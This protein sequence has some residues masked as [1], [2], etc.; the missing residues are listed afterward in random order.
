M[1]NQNLV[2]N[3]G[4]AC[5]IGAAIFS[6]NGIWEI[7]QP[8]ISMDPP[9][10]LDP[11]H[12]RIGTLIFGF[13]CVPAFFA[14]QLGYYLAGATGKNWFAKLIILVFAVGA[15]VYAC[16]AIIQTVTLDGSPLFGIGIMTTQWLCPVLLGIAALFARTVALWKRLFPFLLVIVP[17]I[18]FPIFISNDLPLMG[19]LAINGL[20]WMIFGYVVFSEAKDD[21]N[22]TAS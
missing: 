15:I 11:L 22:K 18:A 17:A 19:A 10:M 3:L 16:G 21:N 4:I 7:L 9:E 14:G 6:A 13:I 8:S 20:G 2:R 5:S 12:F 1:A